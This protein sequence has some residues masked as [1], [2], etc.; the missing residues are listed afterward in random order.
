[1][2][3]ASGLIC[4][5]DGHGVSATPVKDAQRTKTSATTTRT[6]CIVWGVAS[7]AA[8]GARVA[9]AYRGLVA[10]LGFAVTEAPRTRR[11]A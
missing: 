11:P 10:E 6:L 9:A 8:H 3:D 1:V 7:H 5:F 4:L 2:F